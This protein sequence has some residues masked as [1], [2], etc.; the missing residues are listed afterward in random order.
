MKTT[1]RKP[2]FVLLFVLA[3][4]SVFAEPITIKKVSVTGNEVLSR[5]EILDMLSIPLK[6][7]VE[8]ETL[9]ASISSLLES[10]YFKDASY[11]FDEASGTLKLVL[12]EYPAVTIKFSYVGPK[13]IDTDT[14]E[15][16]ALS[17]RNGYPMKP[18]NLIYEIPRT[19][20]K[21]TATLQQEGYFEPF[22]E[23]D[24]ETSQ[25]KTK[26]IN[27]E[28]EEPIEVRFI[29]RTYY[30]WDVELKGT[31]SQTFS[32]TL[33]DVLTLKTF[34]SYHDK[35]AIMRL[36]DKKK[37]YVPK[38]EDIV[39]AVRALY[40]SYLL[41][42][43]GPWDQKAV[44]QLM[45][46]TL[47]NAFQSV[48]P[49][50]VPEGVEP[51]KTISFYV[52]PAEYLETPFNINGIFIKGNE[53]LPELRILEASNL[54]EGQ[55]LSNEELALAVNSIYKLF[56]DNGYPFTSISTS[57]DEERGFLTFE[58]HEPKVREINVEFDGEQKTRDY[59]I[60]DKIVI[61]K[62]KTLNLDDYRNT[63]ALLNSTNYFET[64]TINPVPV[65]KDA[66]DI[67]VMLKEKDR[68]GKFMGG[69]GW[70][71]GINLN[72]DVGILNPFG[73][74]QDIA[75]KLT[76]NIPLKKNKQQEY[77]ESLGATT[78]T[79]SSP[80]YNITLSYSLPKAGGSNWDLSTSA[81]FN[82]YGK[83][84][85]TEQ[86]NASDA[87][88]TT[89]SSKYAEVSFAFSPK[90]RISP[91]SR[92]GFSTGFEFIS[93]ESSVSTETTSSSTSATVITGFDGL[94]LSVNYNYSTRDDLIRPNLG[95]ELAANAYVRGLLGDYEQEFLG[96]RTEY[97]RFIKLGGKEEFTQPV[98][99]PVI[100][101]RLGA[102]QL[103]PFNN[104]EGVY[105]KYLLSPDY[106]IR[107]KT[108][109]ILGQKSY[110]ITAGS[111]QIRF[112]ISNGSIPVDITAFADAVFY[113]DTPNLA[114]F[115]G[116]DSVIDFGL[117]LDI[118]IPMIGV[119]RLG[120]GYNSYLHAKES[121]P[122]WGTFFFGFGPAF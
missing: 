95:T 98:T 64:V 28:I 91:A 111:L 113:R 79:T 37:D 42:R 56:Q 40:S 38:Q 120:Y 76:V 81:A 52:R 68:N 6:A 77:D 96:L 107:V 84:E 116:E 50:S 63:Y 24:W 31:F 85:I 48:K 49:A 112:P 19:K 15:A 80:T 54:K 29:I 17:F 90:Y 65:S 66:L 60:Q 75:T 110:G 4:V 62:G 73:Y 44:Y 55:E 22:Y 88:T 105:E 21:L 46:L 30:L 122:Y 104:D 103:L 5:G 9:E 67:T 78:T 115:I 18:Y 101:I 26:I 16:S 25:D 13:L 71:N 93:K 100:G 61:E 47:N 35:A 33:K 3:L 27:E 109:S 59:L 99:G 20:E 53:N 41:N 2:L 14:L 117:S 12:K 108:S 86:A 10:G 8:R 1:F 51:S 89:I 106:Y 121:E 23:I 102:E 97:K 83:T 70:Q 7:P 34:K 118:S 57:V 45:L 58:I 39:N 11:D 36:F 72:L 114:D 74:G 32:E 87:T 119:V 94:Y 92:I 43:E 82:Y 69:G